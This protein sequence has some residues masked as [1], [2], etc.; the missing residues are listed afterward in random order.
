VELSLTVL[1]YQ[2]LS[3]LSPGYALFLTHHIA[4]EA[5]A[6]LN[7]FNNAGATGASL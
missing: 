5:L 7:L 1:S 2:D 3:P 4:K 6:K